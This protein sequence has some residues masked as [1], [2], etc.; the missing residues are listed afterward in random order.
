MNPYMQT[1]RRVD[2]LIKQYKEHGSLII[3]VDFDFTIYDS[4]TKTMYTYIVNLIIQAQQLNCKLCLW[5]A[6]GTE[7]VERII[8]ECAKYNLVFDYI[9]ESPI[10]LGEDD[11][12]KYHWNILLDDTAG[13]GQAVEI[14]E[15]IIYRIRNN[16]EH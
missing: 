4:D 8:T 2:K 15:H 5:T 1:P 16:N 9:N 13:L 11:I 6:N 12:R 14:L 7:R 3:G 10:N